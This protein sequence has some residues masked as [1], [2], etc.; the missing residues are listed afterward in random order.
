M[1]KAISLLLLLSAFYWPGTSYAQEKIISPADPFSRTTGIIY[2]F[3][4]N[5]QGELSYTIDSDISSN[6]LDQWVRQ[7]LFGKIPKRR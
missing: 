3:L 2:G 6:S 4:S 5:S 1:Y 7:S